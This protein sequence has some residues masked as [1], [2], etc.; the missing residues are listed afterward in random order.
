LF[1]G[2]KDRLKQG[3]ADIDERRMKDIHVKYFV[4]RN[5]NWQKGD[6]LCC[7]IPLKKNNFNKMALRMIRKNKN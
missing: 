7:I 5:P 6:E 4:E 2:K 3:V 1:G